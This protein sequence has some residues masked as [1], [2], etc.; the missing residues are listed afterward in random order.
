MDVTR[1]D[2][3]K[4]VMRPNLKSLSSFNINE[5]LILVSSH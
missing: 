2:F 1:N 3:Y 5:L 4:T